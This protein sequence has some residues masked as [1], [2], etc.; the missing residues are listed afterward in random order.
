MLIDEQRLIGTCL[1]NAEICLSK[2]IDRDVKPEMIEHP[3][4]QKCL[5][6][7]LA[8]FNMGETVS[9]VSVMNAL[10]D[11]GCDQE[12]TEENLRDAAINSGFF[13]DIDEYIKTVIRNYKSVQ[14]RKFV[15]ENDLSVSGI[16]KAIPELM[17]LLENISKSRNNMATQSR[18]L[19]EGNRSNYFIDKKKDT[20]IKTEIP[21]IDE[22]LIGLERGDITVIGARPGVGKSALVTQIIGNV[23]ETLKVGFFNYEMQQNQIYERFLSR[24]MKTGLTRIRKAIQFIGDEKERFDQANEKI[25]SLNFDIIEGNPN[26][27]EI[28]NICRYKQYDL[29]VI[30]Y[31]Q[32]V[33]VEKPG[34]TRNEE[35]GDISRKLKL[36]AMNLNMHIILVSQ[37]NRS[38]EYQMDKEPAMKDLRES[39]NIEQDAANIMLLWNLSKDNYQYKGIVFC[40]GRQNAP[41]IRKVLMFN[42]NDDFTFEYEPNLSVD[43]F[44][45]ES[46][47]SNTDYAPF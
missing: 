2:I 8:Q 39:G 32:L 47:G 11:E 23:A 26:V 15:N 12:R 24:Y 4:Y 7:M 14:V 19:V 18:V 25:E 20:S 38:S 40:K 6:V 28:R 36:M 31:L 42:K 46:Q 10:V 30:D 29:I 27:A 37:L 41:G 43:K 45:P 35:I 3:F 17:M 1:Q 16:E 9:L 44:S 5:R 22:T 34:R 13:T 33:P 21:F